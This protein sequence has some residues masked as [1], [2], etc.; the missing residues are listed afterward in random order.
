MIDL[1]PYDRVFVPLAAMRLAVA[2]VFLSVLVAGNTDKSAPVSTKKEH[3]VAL[4][5]TDSDPTLES[6]EDMVGKV[7]GGNPSR[8]GRFPLAEI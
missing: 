5:V 6:I 4:S 1:R 3:P 8:R 2:V 7:P